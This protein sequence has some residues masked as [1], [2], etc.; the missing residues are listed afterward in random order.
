M[1]AVPERPEAREA[2]IK[3]V[4]LV[5]PRD[6]I[7][8][9][10]REVSAAPERGSQ[11]ERRW[12]RLDDP[13]K[14][15]PLLLV[16]LVIICLAEGCGRETTAARSAREYARLCSSAI[17]LYTDIQP[18]R[19]SDLGIVRCDS[20]LFTF[21]EDEIR[22]S[23]ARLKKLE[24]QFS[25]LPVTNLG[26]REVAEATVVIY[27]LRGGIFAFETLRENVSSPL[28]YCRL[29]EEALWGIPSRLEPPYEG[30]LDAYRARI[31]RLPE[32]LRNAEAQLASPAEAN[33][34]CAIERLDSLI[35]G[36]TSLADSVGRRYGLRL[37]PELERV[38]EAL[39]DF[40]RFALDLLP[41]AHGTLILG[42]EN[43]SKVF[44]YDELL[45][46]D[47]NVL[48]A[49]A[50][51]QIKRL[52]AEKA[53]FE[54]RAGHGAPRR[55]GAEPRKERQRARGSGASGGSTGAGNA[56]PTDEASLERS[57]EPFGEANEPLAS[58]I[59]SLAAR[60]W[61]P[62]EG[63]PGTNVKSGEHPIPRYSARVEYLIPSGKSP[64]LEIEPLFARRA[65]AVIVPPFSAPSC[66]SYLCVSAEASRVGDAELS[67]LLFGGAP[68]VLEPDR[69]RCERRDT[70]AVLFS[71][72]TYTLGWRYLALLQRAR[73]LRVKNLDLYL[74]ILE[75]RQ[76]RLAR[77]VIVFRLH[78][79]SLTMDEATR[80]LVETMGLDP[81][82][83]TREVLAASLSPSVAWPG[84]SMILIE[85]MLKN[86]ASVL[87]FSEPDRVLGNLLLE[88][89]DLPLPLIIP[90]TK[91]D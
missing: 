69:I 60:L 44:L 78:S 61:A 82:A 52:S 66:R 84:I 41:V 85:Q 7:A 5:D 12:M 34:R 6:Y 15:V 23:V 3:A 77:T 20:L 1:S 8:W 72:E 68:E 59:E 26:P 37:D 18:L 91:P 79:G 28:L 29:A 76:I 71:S 38:R 89:R 39:V 14:G 67:L 9:S 88:W 31:L 75:D 36:M 55:P 70:L 10:G 86:T 27:W 17:K 4:Y 16:P 87:G 80:Y 40:R 45:D 58:H 30:E 48:V 47:P 73:E 53:S 22:T 51:S 90:K 65:L 50:E 32:L 49:E 19:S 54:R 35:G 24:S 33:A 2:A 83:A 46:S 43:L 25:D 21:S 62:Q 13:R 74:L 63:K 81:D 42:T 11:P 56:H 57:V 64:Y